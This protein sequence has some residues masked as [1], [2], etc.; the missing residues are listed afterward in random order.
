MGSPHCNSL[1]DSDLKGLFQ[2]KWFFE[3]LD[4]VEVTHAGAINELYLWKGPHARAEEEECEEEA[5]AEMK[6]Y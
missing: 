4:P 2:L 5:V 6:C 3:G 1:L